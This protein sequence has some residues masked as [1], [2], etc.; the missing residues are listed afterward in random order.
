MPVPVSI[1]SSTTAVPAS[2]SRS[3][4][5]PANVNLKAFERRLA[6]TFS[7]RSRS[8]QTGSA[9][10]GQSSVSRSATFESA[11][12]NMP[13]SSAVKAA[14]STGPNRACSRPASS[15]EKSSSAF[16][17]FSKRSAFWC[18]SRSRSCWSAVSGAVESASVSSSGPSMSVSGVRNSWLT[19]EKNAVFAASS[20]PSLRFA[21]RSSL[22]AEASS[23]LRATTSR[24]IRRER[25]RSSSSTSPARTRSVTSSAQC[26]MYRTAPVSDRI[27]MLRGLQNRTWKV[28]SGPRMSYFCTAIVSGARVARTRSSD[29]RRLL[30]PSAVRSAG[31]SGN[32]SKSPCPIVSSRVSSVTASRASLAAIIV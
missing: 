12:W 30:V 29:A 4:M 31:L 23:R 13:P 28:P 17:S 15:R 27:G 3:V 7:K 1:T 18:A 11:D 16:T 21:S 22:T 2:R 8:I 20:S 26:R 5:P 14:R 32:T 24:S 9:R 10:G 19:F 6:T 25:S